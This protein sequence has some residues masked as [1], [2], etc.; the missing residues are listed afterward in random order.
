MCSAATGAALKL[1]SAFA[2]QEQA[3]DAIRSFLFNE[4]AIHDGSEWLSIE[5]AKRPPNGGDVPV[6]IVSRYPQNADQFIKAH[7]L[8]V[9]EN[10]SPVAA[11][12]SMSHHNGTAD[13]S[14]RIR[15]NGYSEV[16]VI[17][18]NNDGKLYM[19]NTFVKASGG[20]SAPPMNI[21]PMSQLTMGKTQLIQSDAVNANGVR[22]FHLVITH[23]NYS[24][25]QK[26]PLET[27][28]IPPHY[29]ESVEIRNSRD[30][31]VLAIAG[32]ISFSEN[33]SFDFSYKP[34]SGDVL[35]IKVIDSRKKVYESQW[36]V[37]AA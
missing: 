8:V 7:H 24:G 12:F 30:E 21:D 10:P 1:G 6:K 9:D 15:I 18:E 31:L 26:D 36:P 5:I 25:M 16:R 14:T 23:P 35:S 2:E 4:R 20:C 17:S 32:D 19:S 27:Y 11:K 3:W 22:N 29:V 37:A 28:F 13:I 33:P 34:D